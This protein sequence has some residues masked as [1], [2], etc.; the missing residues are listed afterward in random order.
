MGLTKPLKKNRSYAK[1][2]RPVRPFWYFLKYVK[3][4]KISEVFKVCNQMF[5]KYIAYYT[6]TLLALL[7]AFQN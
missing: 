2:L 6:K 4:V 3:I 7:L 1:I 5:P